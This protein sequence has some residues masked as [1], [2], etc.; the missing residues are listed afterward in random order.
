MANSGLD[1]PG[2]IKERACTAEEQERVSD[3]LQQVCRYEEYDS[4]VSE[5]GDGT[6]PELATPPSKRSGLVQ[7]CT[8]ISPTNTSFSSKS[9]F[10]ATDTQYDIW[11]DDPFDDTPDAGAHALDHAVE[12]KLKL[13]D[14]RSHL[15]THHAFCSDVASHVSVE[16][17]SET[18]TL[19]EY[20]STTDVAA[21]AAIDPNAPRIFR[22]T[23]CTQ[24]VVADLPC[25]RTVPGCSR[26]KRNGQASLCLLHR[27]KFLDE[28]DKTDP[29]SYSTPVLLRLKDDDEAIWQQKVQLAEQF[30]EAWRVRED[31]KNWVLPSLDGLR[32]HK[33][34]SDMSQKRFRGE[35]MGDLVLKELHVVVVHSSGN[36]DQEDKNV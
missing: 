30:K 7:Y 11:A 17:S 5:L 19:S 20:A 27:D 28:R 9:V 4:E 36:I 1:L 32:C 10:D 25:S 21:A 18:A 34:S 31:R 15:P 24:C 29:L 33:R 14:T 13:S 16:P 2:G 22:I 12:S 6:P 8:E 3:W 26:C 23:S 35:G